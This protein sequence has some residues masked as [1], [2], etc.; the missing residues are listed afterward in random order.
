VANRCAAARAREESYRIVDFL[1][2]MLKHFFKR[3]I[4]IFVK[5]VGTSTTILQN[6]SY[7]FF[8]KE[9]VVQ[10]LSKCWS[11]FF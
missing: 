9:M 1:K 11:N 3:L 7:S 8:S 10:L 6:I 2:K 5:I 4:P